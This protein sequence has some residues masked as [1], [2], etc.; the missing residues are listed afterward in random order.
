MASLAL[1]LAVF[2]DTAEQQRQVS[3]ML[4]GIGAGIILFAVVFGLALIAFF[5]F[6]FWRI[7]TKAGMS[8]AL[9]LLILI[10]PI[11]FI[12][13][14][15]ILAFGDWKVAPITTASPYFPPTYPPPP[16]PPPAFQPP[17]AA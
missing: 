15:C 13:V 3:N 9:S 4:G 1:A 17:P 12:I 8:G 14:L 2:Q 10:Y 5:V 11:G 16:P 7:F 6:L